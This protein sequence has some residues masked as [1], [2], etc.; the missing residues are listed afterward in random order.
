VLAHYTSL[1]NNSNG[2]SGWTVNAPNSNVYNLQVDPTN[3]DIE[4]SPDHWPRRR[5]AEPVRGGQRQSNGGGGGSGVTGNSIIEY[6]GAR[7]DRR[8][9]TPN[10]PRSAWVS[11]PTAICSPRIIQARRRRRSRRFR[12][13]GP[14]QSPRGRPG[15]QQF[16]AY[17]LAVDPA[18]MY[19]SQTRATG[20]IRRSP[21]TRPPR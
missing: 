11:T 16:Y 9:S 6:A 15:E 13:A 4:L 5:A 7:R 20:P 17:G 8:S 3:S 10:D 12:P 2:F 1:T 18:T 19:L 21:N 14:P